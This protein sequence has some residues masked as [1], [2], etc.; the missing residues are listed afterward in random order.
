MEVPVN[1]EVE[2]VSKAH[3]AVPTIAVLACAWP[4][5]LLAT[6]CLLPFLNKPFLIDDPWF[7]AMAQ[8]IVKHPAHPIDFTVCPNFLGFAGACTK[9]STFALGNPLLGQI[10]QG[11]ILVPTV[12]AGAP[13]WAAHLTELLLA[14][15]AILAMTSLTLRL[16]WSRGHAIAGP[17]LLVA[18]PPFLAMASTAMPDILAAT[19]AFVAMERI[20]A[21]KAEEKWSQGAAAAIALGLAGFARPHLVL[22]LPLAAF[23]L[24][25][26]IHPREVLAQVRR[27]FW[28]WTPIIAGGCLLVVIM[29]A[30]REHSPNVPPSYS[31]A[32]HWEHNLFTYFL[33]I[34]FPLPLAACWLVN[35]F[36]TRR[37][38]T[39][40]FVSAAALIPWLCPISRSLAAAYSFAIFGC[41]ALFGLL[42]E[43]LEKRDRST[44]FLLLWLLVPL[45][46]VY[47]MHFPIK[48]FLPCLPAVIFL[49]FRLMEGLPLRVG[50]M[51]ALVAIVAYTGYS[52]LILRSDED[53]AEI[54]RNSLYELIAPHVAAG[55]QVWYSG[56]NWSNWYAPLAGAK[57]TYVGGPQPKRG[58][59]LV[60]DVFAGGDELLA[61]FKH[62]TLVETIHYQY[63]F[64][65]TMGIF[66]VGGKK[67]VG[68]GLYSNGFGY[69]LWGFGE[70]PDDRF[71]LWR[72]D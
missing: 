69:W 34:A 38:M 8:Q 41:G 49:C 53:F 65:R 22:L 54:G 3:Q 36:G 37:R 39:V 40:V 4:A 10:G 7:L 35:R 63:R 61:R 58:D 23:F 25:D 9:A 20:A 24:L 30:L 2:L 71:E 57:L 19:L 50:R 6:L 67:G 13:E 1:A 32:Y 15:I 66:Q 62:R 72:V 70:D 14:W 68:V 46:I 26:S 48:Y 55:E 42:F 12:L 21:W 64:G 27:E 17:L 45:P 5:L 43:V 11:Y 31:N 60:D 59:L 56:T 33:F 28:L 16:G 29:L 18:I 51:A 44:Q 52:I 47:Y